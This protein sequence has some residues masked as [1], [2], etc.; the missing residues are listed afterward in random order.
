MPQSFSIIVPTLNQVRF[1][2]RTLLSVLSQETRAKVETIVMDGGSVDGTIDILEKYS[3]GIKWFSAKDTGQADA[4]NKGLSM[5]TG[6]IIGWLNSD[7]IYLPGTLA[8]VEDYFEKNPDVNWAIGK[9]RIIGENDQEA[10][11]WLTLYK[12]FFLARYSFHTLLIENYISQPAVFIR[13]RILDEMGGPDVRFPLALDYELWL[14]IGKKFQ[15]GYIERFLAAFRI[16][17]DSLSAKN[18]AAQF[19][20][21]YRI[22]TVHDKGVFL[23]LL[24]RINI[25][26]NI[27]GYWLLRKMNMFC[28][29]GRKVRTLCSG[30]A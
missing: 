29:A 25:T 28:K 6:V 5:A 7:D 22:H 24:H 17:P 23:L 8:F 10:R 11:K 21:Q 19:R 16:H 15:P 30:S 1:I 18:H 26:K 3:S 14:R 20:E 4:I 2:E 9:C 13:K 12:N 27:A